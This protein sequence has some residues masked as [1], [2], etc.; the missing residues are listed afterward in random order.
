MGW[1]A[2]NDSPEQVITCNAI[3]QV[4]KSSLFSIRPSGK[5]LGHFGPDTMEH[6][7]PG[8]HQN[9]H[10]VPEGMDPFNVMHIWLTTLLTGSSLVPI[11]DPGDPEVYIPYA[12]GVWFNPFD[13]G[14]GAWDTISHQLY[15]RC[16][17]P[18]G[19]PGA[20]SYW[21]EASFEFTVSQL[22]VAVS[23]QDPPT[24]LTEVDLETGIYYES[25]SQ[26]SMDI[27]NWET[28]IWVDA[29]H[30]L[31]IS[32]F[33]YDVYYMP[34]LGLQ[35]TPEDTIEPVT[36]FFANSMWP[37]GSIDGTYLGHIDPSDIP[38]PNISD[39][40][41]WGL[42]ISVPLPSYGLDVSSFTLIIQPD[43]FHGLPYDAL[44]A[45]PC[46]DFGESKAEANH[47]ILQRF[48]MAILPTITI[49]PPRYKFWDSAIPIPPMRQRQRD[50]GLTTDTRQ[51]RRATSASA[52]KVPDLWWVG[53]PGEEGGSGST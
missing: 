1:S 46:P 51:E 10:P 40:N 36:G 17:E 6:G 9:P 30:R 35:T 29:L 38:D 50:D 12:D 39:E 13:E 8:E 25:S 22:V 32:P 37:T 11:E 18:S 2:W 48:D 4:V 49:Q 52:M 43:T 33:G 15:E 21:W 44:A 27:N 24:Y 31:D 16:Y 45:P 41:T 20:Y 14:H 47:Q 53:A 7:G 42:P 28:I 19:F 3:A 23:I 5:T 26:L 34:G